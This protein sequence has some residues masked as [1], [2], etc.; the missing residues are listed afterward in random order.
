ML[1]VTAYK[2]FVRQHAQTSYEDLYLT[3]MPYDLQIK[4]IIYYFLI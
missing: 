2:I 4:I 3:A 1:K